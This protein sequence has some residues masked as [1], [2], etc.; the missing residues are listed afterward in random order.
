MPGK[1]SIIINGRKTSVH[2]EDE[3]WRGVHEIARSQRTSINDLVATIDRRRGTENLNLS[4]AIRTHTWAAL[5]PRRC[6]RH[7]A[8]RVSNSS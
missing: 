7:R 4:A 5:L 1:R 2:V 6:P 3:F 8:C